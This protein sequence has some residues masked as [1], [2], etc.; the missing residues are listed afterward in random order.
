MT[1]TAL[2]ALDAENEEEEEDIFT[3]FL[4]ED[5]R[6]KDEFNAYI[7]GSTIAVKKDFNLIQ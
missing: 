3:T 2:Q 7:N 6:L 1:E 5:I 4:N